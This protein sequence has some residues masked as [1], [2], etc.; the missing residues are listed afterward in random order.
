MGEKAAYYFANDR[1]VSH[2]DCR[3]TSPTAV[4]VLVSLD[5]GGNITNNIDR[6]FFIKASRG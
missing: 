5:E 1:L 3:V 4:S 6:G 2:N